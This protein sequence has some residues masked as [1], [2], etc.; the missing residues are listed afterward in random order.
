M[1][2]LILLDHRVD[3]NFKVSNYNTLA[4]AEFWNED[5][6]NS[7]NSNILRAN[8]FYELYFAVARRLFERNI[9]ERWGL[10]FQNFVPKDK[11]KTTKFLEG[12]TLKNFELHL[13]LATDDSTI[14]SINLQQYFEAIL[15]GKVSLKDLIVGMQYTT[16][17]G[18]QVI[19]DIAFRDI[20]PMNYREPP[21]REKN[22]K[23]SIQTNHYNCRGYL[24]K[25]KE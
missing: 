25:Y 11:L 20:A 15:A 7:S 23:K 8:T 10:I 12:S 22:T 6:Q 3:A 5:K 18:I 19:H 24:H 14:E 9:E 13:P 1:V 2:I 4:I 16:V 17:P 21:S